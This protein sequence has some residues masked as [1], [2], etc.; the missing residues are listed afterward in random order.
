MRA[1]LQAYAL[2]RVMAT[3]RQSGRRREHGVDLE[4]VVRVRTGE[5]KDEA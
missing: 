5:E 2:D 4:R 1:I 3:Q